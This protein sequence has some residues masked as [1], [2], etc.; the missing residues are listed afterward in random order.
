V[1][2]ASAYPFF[3]VRRWNLSAPAGLFWLLSATTFSAGG[4]TAGLTR[5]D[6]AAGDADLTLR[7]FAEQSGAQVI[8]F[9]DQVRGIPTQAIRGEFSAAEAVRRMLVRTPLTVVQDGKTGAFLVRPLPGRA[10]TESA[11]PARK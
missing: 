9:V 2:F 3:S 5:F 4:V 1:P 6:I 7:K 8:Y 10:A 11:K